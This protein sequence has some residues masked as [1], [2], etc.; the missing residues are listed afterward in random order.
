MSLFKEDKSN[1]NGALT[2]AIQAV[3]TELNAGSTVG[4]V[5]ANVASVALESAVVGQANTDILRNA[6]QRMQKA[7]MAL[8][9]A[10]IKTGA[11]ATFIDKYKSGRLAMAAEAASL[12]AITASALTTHIKAQLSGALEGRVPD[13]AQN[14]V[15]INNYMGIRSEPRV[16]YEYYDEAEIRNS[17]IS[18]TVLNYAA[19]RQSPMVEMFYG[20]IVVP[21]D[22]VGYHM[23]L[24]Q[25]NVMKETLREL[26]G[27]Y[28]K[29]FARINL[30]KAQIDHTILENNE[31]DVIPVYRAESADKFVDTNDVAPTTVSINGVNFETAP[32]KMGVDVDLLGI[33]QNAALLKAGTLDQTDALDPCIRIKNLY[34]KADG[35][36]I[37]LDNITY[38]T[39][40]NFVPA[41][42]GDAKEMILAF[43]VNSLPLTKNTKKGDG[44]AL[45]GALAA[46]KTNEWVVRLKMV[47]TGNCNV[48]VANTSVNSSGVTVSAINDKDRNPVDMTQGEGK[49]IVDAIKAGELIGFDLKAFRTNSNKRTRGILLDMSSYSIL[50]SIPLL[51]PIS[52]NRPLAKG[53]EHNQTDLAALITACRTFTTNRGVTALFDTMEL[54]RSYAQEQRMGSDFDSEYLG[55]SRKLIQ[56]YFDDDELDVAAV[57]ASLRSED[58]PVQV[59]AAMVNKLRDMIFRG[60]YVSGLQPAANAVFAGEAPMPTVKIGCDPVVNRYLQVQGDLRTIGGKFEVQIE[61]E[62]DNRMK[63]HIF[64]AFGYQT[65]N[66]ENNYHPLNFGMMLWKPEVVIAAPIYRNGQTSSELTVQPSF[67]H[68]CNTPLLLHLHIK[69]ISAA[70]VDAVPVRVN[71][72]EPVVTKPVQA[73]TPAPTNP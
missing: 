54:L 38:L 47:V 61:P 51:G 41:P 28:K 32:L 11:E 67:L 25:I 40:A 33:S 36:V 31:T 20:S 18:T 55:I 26:S 43:N 1:L 53:D 30:V 16:A 66:G 62:W 15:R 4:L 45:T 2:N 69:N 42:Q 23:R 73:A 12:G 58:R 50:Y 14:A 21:P 27:A 70:A 63:D 17:V 9:S 56:P 60:Y 44:S 29:D 39:T 24:D 35:N 13:G 59:Q 64:V 68:V 48:Q 8:E 52:T 71:V 3:K 5:D 7:L 22:Q 19:S 72:T 34:L 6:S 46:I 57:V 65:A 37:K 49:A 10:D